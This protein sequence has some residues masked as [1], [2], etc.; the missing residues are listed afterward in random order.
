LVLPASGARGPAHV[1]L[2][3]MLEELRV[4][5]ERIAGARIGAIAGGL[6]AGGRRNSR[7]AAVYLFPWR[8]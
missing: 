6:H 4:P 5:V 2:P 8:T 3:K 1:G 7:P